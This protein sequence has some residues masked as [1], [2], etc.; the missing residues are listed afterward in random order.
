MPGM[1]RIL[2]LALIY[3]AIVFGLGFVL[4]TIR[5]LVIVPRLGSEGLAVAL[6]L[7]A[8][9]AA[10]WLAARWLIRRWGPL[11]AV[12]RAFIGGLAFMLLIGAE[13]A[14]AVTLF[15]ETAAQWFAAQFRMPGLMGLI[16]QI[17]F[18]MMP[19]LVRGNQ[20]RA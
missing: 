13:A 12:E 20:G 16:A 3:W 2:H 8:M 17:A 4:G 14:L 9:L 10:S 6:E 19:L 7:P 15:G 18:G 11:R 5:V 1:R